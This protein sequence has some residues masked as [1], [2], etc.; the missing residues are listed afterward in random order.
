MWRVGFILRRR[1]PC[2]RR[3]DTVFAKLFVVTQRASARVAEIV[4]FGPQPH[5]V[6]FGARD[7]RR[8]LAVMLAQFRDPALFVIGFTACKPDVTGERAYF[9]EVQCRIGRGEILN[10]GLPAHERTCRA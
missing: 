4:V 9:A 10:Q 6:V 1:K 3:R 8:E 2:Q 5:A 7:Y